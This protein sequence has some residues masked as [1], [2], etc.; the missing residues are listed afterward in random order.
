[1][2][3]RLRAVGLADGVGLSQTTLGEFM[4]RFFA[5][6]TGKPSTRISY[7]NVRRNLEQYFGSVRLLSGIST[8][9]A[10]GW[11][12]WMVEH[13][14]LATP[15]ISRRVIAARTMW[16]KAIRWKLVSENVFKGVKT[17]HQTN[18]ARKFFVPRVVIDRLID[19]APD[20]E[21]KVII[22]LARYGGLRVPS[23]LYALRWGDVNWDRGAIRVPCPKLAH[24]ESLAY[25]TVPLFPEIRMHLLNLFEE[26]DAGAEYVITK[27][28]LGCQNLRQQLERH[29]TRAGMAAWP[30]LFH[31]LRASRETELMREYDLAT[32]CK[33]IG[34]SPAVAAKHYA[35]SVDLN[36]DFQ[37]ATGQAQQK[38][39]QSADDSNVLPMTPTGEET[40]K[41]LIN[42]GFG[43]PCRSLANAGK[44][45]KWAIQGSNL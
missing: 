32:V 3:K 19:D 31:N 40:Q 39:Q 41:A 8:A 37:R 11:R 4:E 18:E 25:R 45:G 16:H 30:K 34:N 20:T 15:T 23:E 27:H 12:A 1:M 42:Q 35:I 6:L 5:T 22:A 33:W 14:K 26:A 13:E 24:H 17:G 10:D 29:I 38:A 43:T 7:S 36:A 21:W 2:L 44:T 28:R 9:D